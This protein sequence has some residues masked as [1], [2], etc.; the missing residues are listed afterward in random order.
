MGGVSLPEMIKRRLLELQVGEDI[1]APSSSSR[2]HASASLSLIM[3]LE[4]WP[5][6]PPLWLLRWMKYS[7]PLTAARAFV[8]VPSNPYLLFLSSTSSLP[9]AT[10]TVGE[11]LNT[12]LR[13]TAHVMLMLNG[14]LTSPTHHL[15]TLSMLS[16]V[17]VPTGYHNWYLSESLSNSLNLTIEYVSDKGLMF[18][19]I[20]I[21]TN[22]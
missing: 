5:L 1:Q 16:W 10:F 15:P 8:L 4:N 17:H 6:R 20:C 18:K 7:N 12:L 21:W 9:L 13:V 2:W 11:L 14:H 19:N 3:H 22:F